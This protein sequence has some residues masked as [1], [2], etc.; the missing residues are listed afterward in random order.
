MADA[1]GNLATEGRFRAVRH[2]TPGGR[3]PR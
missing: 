1:R 2:A 3:G